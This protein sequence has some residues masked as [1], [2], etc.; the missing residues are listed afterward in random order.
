MEKGENIF[1]VLKIWGTTKTIEEMNI[2]HFILRDNW[3][4]AEM[5]EWVN[6]M[7]ELA[8]GTRLGIP[9]LIT[10]NSRNENTEFILG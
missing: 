4:P 10:S 2:R 9:V 6:K 7:N 5:A 1:A 3:S 8:E